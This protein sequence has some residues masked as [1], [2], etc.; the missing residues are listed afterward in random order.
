MADDASQRELAERGGKAAAGRE[1]GA[2]NAGSG[3][4]HAADRGGLSERSS[5]REHDHA[6]SDV[7]VAVRRERIHGEYTADSAGH[8]GG[9]VAADVRQRG[10]ADAGAVCVAAAGDCD[11]AVAGRGTR[12]IVRQMVLE[13]VILALCAGA[14]ALLLTVWT[15]KTFAR[16]IPPNSNPIVLN[17][18]VDPDVVIGIV[19]LAVLASVLCGAFPAWRSSQVPAAEV[20]KEESA[21]VSGGAHNRRLLS[22]LVVAQIAL[23]LALLVCSG[24]FLRTLRNI[25]HA[26]PGF[27]QDHVLTASVGLNIVWL[28]RTTKG[29][30]DS[31]QDS[32]ARGGIAGRDGGIAYRLGSAELEPEDGGCVSGRVCAAPA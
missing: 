11:P 17:G 2:G 5:G 8:C 18:M 6:G 7:A 32:R 27:E 31:P 30:V 4:D 19:V 13:G 15:A 9:G 16:F 26:D 29:D 3:D 10:H 20:L 22:G 14:V 21:S 28:L 23:S 12:A 25:A 1:P 24:L